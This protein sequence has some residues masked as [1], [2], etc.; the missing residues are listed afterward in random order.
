MFHIFLSLSTGTTEQ[1]SPTQDVTAGHDVTLPC[2]SLKQHQNKCHRITWLF[3]NSGHAETLFEHGENKLDKPKSDRLSLT[4]SC[5]LV[6]KKVTDQDAGLYTCIRIR[7]NQPPKDSEVQ[8]SV[9]N[10]EYLHLN[11][12]S[13]NCPVRPETSQ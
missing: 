2:K 3:K 12:F 10:S 5:S 11:V 8:L 13:S 7:N 6:I 4:V 1:H 9:T